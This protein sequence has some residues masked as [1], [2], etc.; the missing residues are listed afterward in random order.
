MKRTSCPALVTMKGSYIVLHAV[1]L[2]ILSPGWGK[3]P[4]T[5]QVRLRPP[6]SEADTGV[7]WN[8]VARGSA[9][10]FRGFKSNFVLR[11]DK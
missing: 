9:A 7:T 6:P 11:I 5:A 2:T 3:A 4:L 8:S 10:E 1:D